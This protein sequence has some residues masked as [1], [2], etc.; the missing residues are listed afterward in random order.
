MYWIAWTWKYRIWKCAEISQSNWLIA[1]GAIFNGIVLIV[2][3]IRTECVQVWLFGIQLFT[4]WQFYLFDK[5]KVF[6][7]DLPNLENILYDCSLRVSGATSLLLN[8]FSFSSFKGMAANV[9]I[10]IVDSQGQIGYM[11]GR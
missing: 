9:Y 6:I 5:W 11:W 10:R 1:I 8:G 4:I 7:Q 3:S 2:S